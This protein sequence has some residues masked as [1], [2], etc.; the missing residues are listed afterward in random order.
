MLYDLKHPNIIT[1]R[2]VGLYQERPFIVMDYFESIT[3]NRALIDY[4]KMPPDKA[5]RMI[6]MITSAL[7]HAH[8]KNIVHRDLTPGNIILAPEDCRVIDFGLGVYIE[9]ALKSR[10]THPG[11]A[12]A[13]GNFAARELLAD[14]T[15]VDARSDIFSIGALWYHA[16]TND[17]PAG[18]EL[19]GSLAT[20]DGLPESHQ[21]VILKCLS[22][23]ENRYQTC[24]ELQAAISEAKEQP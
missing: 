12:P 5:L 8:D 24:H 20:V 13:G 18:S 6:E 4:G 1:V 23:I 17:Y 10:L 9:Q 3:L 22:D 2:E 19:A 7:G 16:V 21:R 11:E 14:P 15:L